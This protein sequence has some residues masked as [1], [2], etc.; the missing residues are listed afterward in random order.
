M[1][2]FLS[3][4]RDGKIFQGYISLSLRKVKIGMPFSDDFTSLLVI[5]QN[6]LPVAVRMVHIL[7]VAELRLRFSKVIPD[8]ELAIKG[9]IAPNPP[10]SNIHTRQLP[11][12]HI[13]IKAGL[14]K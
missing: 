3:V 14:V 13:R 10:S 2:F 1:F 5:Y 8:T 12:R 11:E 6:G 4:A 7:L 9:P